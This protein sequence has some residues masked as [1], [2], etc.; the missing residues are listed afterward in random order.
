M[1]RRLAA[2]I[3]KEFIQVRRDPRTLAL[4]LVMPVMQLLLFGYAITTTIDH[5]PLVVADLARSADSRA[6]AQALVNSTYF[7]LV[8]HVDGPA[9]A[10]QAID[11]GRAKVA[12]I[13]P[14]DFGADVLAGRAASVLMLVDGSDPNTASTAL[15]AGAQVVR[16]Q[17]AEL[18]DERRQRLGQVGGDPGGID[19]RPSVLYNPSM[20][21]VNYMIPGLIG[22]ILQTQAVILTSFAVVR[23]RERGTLEQLIVTPIRSG[24]LMLGKII[25]FIVITFLQI[26]LALMMGTLW[27]RV[28]I[29]GSVVLLLA[30]SLV[31]LASALGIGLLI[32]SVSSTQAQAMQASLFVML[33]SILLS[34]FMFPTEAMPPVIQ[35]LTRLLPLTY[36]LQVL[37]GIILKGNDIGALWSQVGVL[38]LFGV[39]IFTLSALRFRKRLD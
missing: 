27:F 3:V 37:R 23:E 33:P 38:A 25:P 26:G 22:L 10:R 7:T 11:L 6:L 1:W 34:G 8:G 28:P 12:L 14:P 30:L 18:A 35:V 39:A 29:N 16:A 21:S 13:V 32:S 4:V 31:F 5:I 19:L 36:Y 17:G 15:F 9:E 2:I 24:E 20:E